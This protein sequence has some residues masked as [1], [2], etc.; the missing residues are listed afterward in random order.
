MQAG[1]FFLTEVED[2]SVE[3]TMQETSC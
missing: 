3:H 1:F 2:T